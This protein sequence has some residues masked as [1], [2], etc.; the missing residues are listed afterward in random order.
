MRTLSFVRV[1]VRVAG[2][3]VVIFI[4]RIIPRQSALIHRRHV[5]H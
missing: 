5:P 2:M 1:Y 4:Y 3:Y